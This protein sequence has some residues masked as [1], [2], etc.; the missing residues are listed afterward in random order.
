MA[1]KGKRRGKRFK[2]STRGLHC[3]VGPAEMGG[4]RAG[5]ARGPRGKDARVI[6]TSKWYKTKAGAIAALKLWR[7]K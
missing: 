5:V 7:G 1:M 6:W 4:W 3:F 2:V